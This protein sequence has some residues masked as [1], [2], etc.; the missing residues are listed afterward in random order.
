MRA[1]TVAWCCSG[2][3]GSESKNQEGGNEGRAK[4]KGRR[5]E[6]KRPQLNNLGGVFRWN[7]NINLPKN[8]KLK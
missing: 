1:M 7:P 5:T 6:R 2:G 8:L 3:S 4:I